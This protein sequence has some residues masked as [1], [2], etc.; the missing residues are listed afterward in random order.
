MS[1]SLS[2]LVGGL[3]DKGVRKLYLSHDPWQE[4]EAREFA[5]R[6]EQLGIEIIVAADVRPHKDYIHS[7]DDMTQVWEAMES[8]DGCIVFF[9]EHNDWEN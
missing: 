1:P 7:G 5:T 2:E 8:C 4:W 9:K 6:L 3:K